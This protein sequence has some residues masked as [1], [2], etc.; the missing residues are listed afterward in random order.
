MKRTVK[1]NRRERPSERRRVVV[2]PVHS[3]HLR[4]L[5]RPKNSVSHYLFI[6]Q[7]IEYPR[8]R[9]KGTKDKV[10]LETKTYL[11]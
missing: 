10:G 4:S 1:S 5:I 6:C 7:M 8:G 2:K 11:V 9:G 3:G